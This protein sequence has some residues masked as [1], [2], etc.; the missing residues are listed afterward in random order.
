MKVLIFEYV[1]GGGFQG[2]GAPA[3]LVQ[4]GRCMWQAALRDFSNAL[5]LE[6]VYTL[7]ESRFAIEAPGQVQVLEP[8][9]SWTEHW[10]RLLEECDV[11]LVIAPEENQILFN[12]CET[13]QASN[14]KSLNC[15]LEAIALAGDKLALNQQ[16][17][18]YDI[19]AIPTYPWPPDTALAPRIVIKPREGAG[20]EDTFVYEGGAIPELDAERL[21]VW[22]PWVEGQSVS[23]SVLVGRGGA[24][25]LSCN[26]IQCQ[27]RGGRLQFD[28]VHAGALDHD[29]ALRE[30]GQK[31]SD[32]IEESISGL[33]GYIGIDAQWDGQTLTLLE[34]NP[35]LTLSY[36][37]VGLAPRMLQACQQ[38]IPA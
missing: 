15:T 27:Q 4:Q 38:E 8:T 33:Q 9:D 20:C 1:V 32:Q 5:G 13:V 31:L 12:L 14:C 2:A 17:R 30:A 26:Q 19:Q 23:F 21:W 10:Y 16:L 35:R 24:E 29:T 25:V 6:Q 28:D 3:A 11:A 36:T 7:I 18:A 37:G 34:I 22:Q